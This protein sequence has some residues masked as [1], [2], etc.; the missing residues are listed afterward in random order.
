MEDCE[1]DSFGQEN[2]GSVDLG[3]AQR[4]EC[5][6]KIANLLQRHPG[7]T[8]PDKLNNP[9]NYNSMLNLANRPE[10]THAAVLQ[11]HRQR[12]FRLMQ[13]A[14]SPIVLLIHD[15]T[16][17]DYS[18]L[19][20]LAAE[21]GE[22]GNGS[23]RGYLCH[24][25][26]AVD[27]QKR[28]V[29][30]L[31]NQLLH[32]REPVPP[33]E[34]VAAKR[35][36]ESRESRLWTRA[37][38]AIGV[39]ASDKTCVDVCDRGADAFEFLAYEVQAGRSFLIRSTQ[40]RSIEADAEGGCQTYLHDYAR[41]LQSRGRRDLTLA[42]RDS[43]P[44]RKTQVAVSWAR[45]RVLPPQVQRGEYEKRPLDLWVIRVWEIDPP[46]GEEAVEWI[47]LT[48]VAISRLDEAWERVDWY[49][50]RWIVEEYHKAQKTGCGIEEMQFTTAAALQPMI[51]LLSIVAITL[52]NLRELAHGPDA[53]TRPATEVVSEE[54]VRVLSKWRYKEVRMDMTIHDYCLA[55]ARLG[56]YQH[57][58]GKLPGWLV[59]WRGWMKLEYILVGYKIRHGT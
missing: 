25:S 43:K 4:N 3:H 51:A 23:R 14:A 19:H 37:V 42:A 26:L 58:R 57:R 13:E 47:L 9:T 1:P 32:C 49:E 53:Q 39:V 59:L 52:L 28:E 11:P 12:T 35:I 29:L 27:P 16:E 2:F 33:Q 7:G 10:V 44:V 41:T 15:T 20:S 5:L 31:A 48:N 22:I 6:I 18:G 46:A 24:N 17:L 21:L 34:S 36:R 40:S 50:C 45:V 8:L 38:E 56:G 30:G 55:L 54:Y